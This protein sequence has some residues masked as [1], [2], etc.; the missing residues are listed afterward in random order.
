MLMVLL[1]GQVWVQTLHSYYTISR[2]AQPPT[3]QLA[4]PPVPLPVPGFRLHYLL[5]VD[6]SAM[7][8]HY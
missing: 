1:E 5:I 3:Q 6:P 2:S 8:T 7:S 4:C